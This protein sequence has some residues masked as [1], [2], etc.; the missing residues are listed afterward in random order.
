MRKNWFNRLLLSYLPV[1]FV[2]SLS[3]LLIMYLMLSEMSKRS[4]VRANDLL[5]QNIMQTIDDALK[6]IDDTMIREILDNNEMRTFFQPD[7]PDDNRYADYQ[8]AAALRKILNDN[9]FID[10][11]YLYRVSGQMV[12]TTTAFIGIDSFGDKEFIGRQITSLTPHYWVTTRPYRERPDGLAVNVISL[13]KFTNLSDRSLIVVNVRTDSLGELIRKMSDS[14][15]NFVELID[16]NEKLIASKAPNGASSYDADSPNTGKELSSVRSN[17]TG[18]TVRSGIYR[19]NIVEW[20]SSLFYV[21]ISFGCL[22]IVAGIVWFVYVTR[23]NY[24][25]IRN[26]ADRIEDY[27]KQKR[28]HLKL[29]ESADEFKYIETAIEDLLNQS[30]ILQEQNKENLAYRRRHVFLEMLE[31]SSIALAD[32]WISEFDQLGWNGS[33]GGYT[34]VLVEMDRFNEFASQ[35]SRWDQFLLKHVLSTVNQELADSDPV[36]VW[37]EWVDDERLAVVYMLDA[38][39]VTTGWEVSIFCEKWRAW[40]EQ[41]LTFT[42][43]IGIGTFQEKPEQITQS[44]QSAVEALAYKSSLG[45]NRLIGPNDLTSLPQGEMF[46]QLSNIRAICQYFRAGDKEWEKHF[47]DLRS[48]VRIQLFSHDELIYLLTSLIDHLHKEVMELPPEFQDIWN[49]GV[50]ER[51]HRIAER[52][53]S[54]D[55]IFTDFYQ[56]LLEAAA[57]MQQVREGRNHHRLI[58][59]V[60]KYI[61]ENYA[62]SE[63]S[64]AHLS[65]AFGVNASYV[66]RLFKDEYGEKFN[67]YVAQVRIEKAIGLL[68][69][70]TS[71]INEIATAVGYTH[72]LTFIRVFKKLTGSTPGNYRKDMT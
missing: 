56:V 37:A 45:T 64:L 71:T 72:P 11:I 29:E 35:Y 7:R 41:N 32:N 34:V 33:Q 49:K 23:R 16:S 62:N 15:L 63:L 20:V 46:K 54:A 42:V 1:L 70:T 13:V 55:E 10:S 5:S 12:L 26:I 30:S 40:V 66:S 25:P 36:Q 24:T 60:K 58:H 17:Y 61:G 39:A 8:T 69:E 65:D 50:E 53:E 27:A 57:Q 6:G 14:K 3:L 44:Y 67:D 22:V 9:R 21:W 68:K 28:Q 19:A 48:T 59:Q 43:T 31:G 18:W 38:Y 47:H 4:A 52:I 2:V 51:L